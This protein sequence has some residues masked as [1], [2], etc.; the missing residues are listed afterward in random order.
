MT[1][2]DVIIR[3]KHDWSMS[4]NIAKVDKKRVVIVG[5]G[6]SYLS[7]MSSISQGF[8][9]YLLQSAL[10]S[11]LCKKNFGFMHIISEIMH[12]FAPFLE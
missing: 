10:F 9:S 5:G 4:L 7:Y 11:L 8:Q 2:P 1:H 3:I 12:T 6:S